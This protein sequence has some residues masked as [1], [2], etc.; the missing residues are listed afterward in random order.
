[1]I[2][3]IGQKIKSPR[4]FHFILKLYCDMC[5]EIIQDDNYDDF[6]K[7]PTS[8]F[9]KISFHHIWGLFIDIKG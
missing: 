2:R 4:K 8:Y 9:H 5:S 3:P 7:C 6:S 1:M